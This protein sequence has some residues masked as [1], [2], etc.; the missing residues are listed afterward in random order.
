MALQPAFVVE[1][2]AGPV[3]AVPGEL[4]GVGLEVF[5]ELE[6]LLP[7]APL[8]DAS[9]PAGA[10]LPVASFLPAQALLQIAADAARP[11]AEPVPVWAASVVYWDRLNSF[12]AVCFSP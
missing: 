12:T 1:P 4:P 7:E 5:P 2:V 11:Q 8:A 3:L 9:D 6:A 10:E